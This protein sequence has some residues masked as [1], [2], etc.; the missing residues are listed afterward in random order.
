MFCKLAI[1]N[2]LIGDEIVQ[3]RIS[4]ILYA[5]TDANPA[6]LLGRGWTNARLFPMIARDSEG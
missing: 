6:R 4:V 3:K 5:G 1:S 2:L